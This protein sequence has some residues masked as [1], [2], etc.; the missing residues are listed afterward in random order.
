LFSAILLS[1]S[2]FPCFSLFLALFAT[3][4]LFDFLFF[5]PL[6]EVL[7]SCL[8]SFFMGSFCCST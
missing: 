1:D 6:A 8:V 5:F 7:F 4:L 2:R 3:L